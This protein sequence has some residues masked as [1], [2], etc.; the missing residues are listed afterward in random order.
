M[1]H[2]RS[3]GFTL[4]ELLV[5]IAI[6]AI[7]ASL[8]LPALSNAKSR[9]KQIQCVNNLKQIGVTTL[10]YTQD[11]GGLLPINAP[12]TPG[13]TWASLLSTNTDLRT[14]SVFLCPS[15]PPHKF[16]NWFRTYGVRLD[17]PTNS[18]RGTFQE[19]LHI[20]SLPNPVEYL[21]VADTTSRG[22]QGIGSQQFYFFRAASEKEVHAR[23]T[24]KSNGLFLDGHVES[25][26]R[27]RL[28]NL[29]IDALFEADT[30]P[31]YFGG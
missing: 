30:I 22:R 1:S 31:G 9:A 20:D 18:T 17:P 5:V 27:H 11:H 19:Y 14:V 12:L 4:I 2:H 24:L 6:I 3:R 15:Y 26:P 21:H 7:L 16:T 10:L 13:A 23:H 29:G 8:L 28:E 25:C